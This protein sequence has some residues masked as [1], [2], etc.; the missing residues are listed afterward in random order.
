[1]I[2]SME[3][4]PSNTL[5]RYTLVAGSLELTWR[6][7]STQEFLPS[8][9]LQLPSTARKGAEAKYQHRPPGFT[10]GATARLI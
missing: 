10:Y 4:V 6:L 2:S 7:R 1:M 8:R 9:K 3:K 5:S